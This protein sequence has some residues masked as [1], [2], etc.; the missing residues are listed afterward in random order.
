MYIMQLKLLRIT[1]KIMGEI[2]III[3]HIRRDVGI[4]FQVIFNR[5]LTVGI[6]I[7]FISISVEFRRRNNISTKFFGYLNDFKKN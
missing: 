1:D 2:E 6:I 4:G 7:P 3:L 5:Y